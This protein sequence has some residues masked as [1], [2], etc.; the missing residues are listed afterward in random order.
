QVLRDIRPRGLPAHQAPAMRTR[1]RLVVDQ[2]SLS[3]NIPQTVCGPRELVRAQSRLKGPNARHR[4]IAAFGLQSPAPP[5]C[6][7]C[8]RSLVPAAVNLEKFCL[9]LFGPGRGAAL[10]PATGNR[11]GGIY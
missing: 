2:P 5:P 7:A 3:F 9:R 10:R 4:I 6:P 1:D 8:P 11:Y